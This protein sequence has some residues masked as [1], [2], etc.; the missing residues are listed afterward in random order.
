MKRK[1]RRISEERQ[2]KGNRMEG[3]RKFAVRRAVAKKII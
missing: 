2:L 3:G 1:D